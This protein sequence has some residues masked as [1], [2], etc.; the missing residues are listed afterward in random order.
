MNQCWWENIN[1]VTKSAD[2][3]CPTCPKYNPRESVHINSLDFIQLPPFMDKF[4]LVHCLYVFSLDQSFL[5][6]RLNATSVRKH[7]PYSKNPSQTS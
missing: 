6:Q 2:L 3:S 1:K 5:L 7:Y 4:V